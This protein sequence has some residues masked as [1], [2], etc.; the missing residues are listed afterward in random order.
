MRTPEHVLKSK[1][2]L[3]GALSAFTRQPWEYPS[4]HV[5]MGLDCLERWPD[6]PATAW[7]CPSRDGGESLLKAVW[8]WAEPYLL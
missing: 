7:T 6:E 3:Y 8:L 2:G 5:E 4:G 1:Y